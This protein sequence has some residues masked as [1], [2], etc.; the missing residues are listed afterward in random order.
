MQALDGDDRQKVGD[1]SFARR[2]DGVESNTAGC[3][4]RA[5]LTLAAFVTLPPP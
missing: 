1:G 3:S 4:G 2:L 5:C